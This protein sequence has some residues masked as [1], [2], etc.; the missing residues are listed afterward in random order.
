MHIGASDRAQRPIACRGY[1][2]SKRYPW[3][4]ESAPK[5]R[6]KRYRREAVVLRVDGISD[7]NVPQSGKHNDGVQLYF[8]SFMPRPMF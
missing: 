5:S 8:I 2:W 6:Y 3:I 1:D 7:F 4:V